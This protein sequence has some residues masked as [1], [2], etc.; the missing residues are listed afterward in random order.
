MKYLIGGLIAAAVIFLGAAGY[1]IAQSYSGIQTLKQ[2][3]QD[4]K[5]QPPVIPVGTPIEDTY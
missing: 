3:A 5:N 1:F 4:A 2:Q